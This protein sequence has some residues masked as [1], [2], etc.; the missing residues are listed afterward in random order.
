[1]KKYLFGFM[2]AFATMAFVALPSAD[3]QAQKFQLVEKSI[4]AVDTINFLLVPSHIK[5]F[6]YTYL[7]T[8]GTTAGK[9]YL[10]GSV[11]TGSWELLDSLTLSDVTTLQKKTV[12][13]TATS[14]AN[15]RWRNTNT[16]SAVAAV[17]ATWLRREDE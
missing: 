3:C 14:Y 17:K 13:I 11:I 15:Y 4:T 6:A 8:S 5:A 1:M 2:I 12:I 7:E 16:S 9:V 10:E